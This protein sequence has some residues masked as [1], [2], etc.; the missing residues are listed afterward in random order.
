MQTQNIGNDGIKMRQLLQT[1]HV[2]YPIESTQLATDF[3]FVRADD[4]EVIKVYKRVILTTSL[5]EL[6]V[7][8]HDRTC[9]YGL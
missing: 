5:F 3:L 2:R 4:G 7:S 1:F 9:H 8:C 6:S